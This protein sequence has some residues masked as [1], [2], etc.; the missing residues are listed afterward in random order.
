MPYPS[1]NPFQCP[2]D[3]TRQSLRFSTSSAAA[4]AATS[5]RRSAAASWQSCCRRKH[6]RRLQGPRGSPA[7]VEDLAD[8]SI[9]IYTYELPSKSFTS[10]YSCYCYGYRFWGGLSFSRVLWKSAYSRSN[11]K[12]KSIAKQARKWIEELFCRFQVLRQHFIFLSFCIRLHE[13]EREKDSK[14]VGCQMI[15]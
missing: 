7:P 9:Y 2:P 10:E 6:N 14:R 11:M 12:P 15:W 8:A 3:S 5:G 1:T 4:A 13:R